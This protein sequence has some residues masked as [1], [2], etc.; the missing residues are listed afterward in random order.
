[1][2]NKGVVVTLTIVI[3][4]LCLYYLSF[5]FVTAK[6]NREAIAQATDKDGSIDLSKKQAYLDSLWNKPVYNIFG[7]EYT[8]KEIKDNELSLGLDLQ[9]GMHV[10][11]EISPIDIVKGLSGNNQDPAFIAALQT[12]KAMEK[13]S[14]TPF[15]TLFYKAFKEANPDRS[16]S[17]L[18]TSTA[19]KDKVKLSDSDDAV[20]KF[21]DKEVKDAID[22]SFTIL[23]TRIDQFGTSQPNIQ[24]LQGTNRIQIEIPGAD[25]PQRVRKLL[26]GVARLEFWEIIE[27]YDPQ[28][29]QSL[30]AI[31][32]MLM[33]EQAAK[34]LETK[35]IAPPEEKKSDKLAD[36]LNAKTDTT[37]SALE[38]QLTKANAK[39][40]ASS[41]LDS[42]RSA[43]A[44]PLF[45][46]STQG[47]SFLYPV[48]DT[49]QINAIFKREEVRALLPRTVGFFW[50]VKADPD[51][52][53]GVE[54][55]KLNFVNLGRSGKPL[56]TGDVITDARSDF[57]QFARPSVSMTMN[58]AGARTLG[59]SNSSSFGQTAPRPYR[60][61]A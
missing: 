41:S 52:T 43:T 19:N 11:L 31:N 46:L 28:I 35:L 17:S 23:K 30:I 34:K 33:K 51:V 16:L 18:F 40:S 4:A 13:K 8:Y 38:K 10:V 57:D 48:K 53:P 36:Q 7:A 5:T 32:Q 25:N 37:R 49:A 12:A 61:R 2:R 59:E 47:G 54:D 15:V 42:L 50:D 26:Q 9:G 45:A 39:D 24:R 56:L 14:S 6:I 22:R 21:L 27:P 3:T 60:Y 1:M 29:S 55:I 58:A 44:S 20:I